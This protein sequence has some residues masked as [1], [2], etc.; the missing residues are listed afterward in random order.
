MGAGG[1]FLGKTGIKTAT[2]VAIFHDSR[3]MPPFKVEIL[4]LMQLS[5]SI[6]YC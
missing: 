3:L 2:A 6:F 5:L 1:M 4:Y